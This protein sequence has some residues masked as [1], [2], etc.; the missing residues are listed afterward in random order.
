[1]CVRM[2]IYEGPCARK[3]LAGTVAVMSDTDDLAT[4]GDSARWVEREGGI[5]HPSPTYARAFLGLVRAGEELDRALDADLRR[6]HGIGLRA[7]EVLLHLAAFAP[8]G[9]LRISQL[10][11]QAP[12][13]Q[14]RVSRL[15]A[16]LEADGLVARAPA[17]DDARGVE[18]A[19]TDRGMDRLKAVQDTHH[20]SLDDRLFS[21]LSHDQIVQLGEITS[22]ILAERV[23]R[24]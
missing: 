18:V 11:A 3:Y 6:A 17:D 15:V 5:R 14:S 12:L 10:T 7:Y 2:N 20:Q 24:D 1:M 4:K 8:D 22:A 23:E 13:S 9:H 21:K 16:E 19:I